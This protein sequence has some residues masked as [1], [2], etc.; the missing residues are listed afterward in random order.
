[1]ASLG[2]AESCLG[3][4]MQPPAATENGV[5]LGGAFSAEPNPK[6]PR[7]GLLVTLPA[8]WRH[9]AARQPSRRRLWLKLVCEINRQ[10]PVHARAN[11]LA[12]PRAWPRLEKATG[13]CSCSMVLMLPWQFDIKTPGARNMLEHSV[14]QGHIIKATPKTG[15]AC[16]SVVAPNMTSKGGR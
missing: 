6:P 9:W 12:S 10:G 15:R 5:G 4:Y 16:P 3:L 13:D 14:G 2:R 1:M 7:P 11:L 8:A